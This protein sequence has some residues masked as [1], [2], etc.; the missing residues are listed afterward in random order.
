[1]AGPSPPPNYSGG[2]ADQ[3]RTIIEA[4]P[5]TL[6]R[7]SVLIYLLFRVA[8]RR[9]AVRRSASCWKYSVELV[10]EACNSEMDV[11]VVPKNTKNL[12]ERRKYH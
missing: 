4:N 9:S 10:T 3:L 5:P 7:W 12:L 2:G 11:E 1:M 8:A 6:S